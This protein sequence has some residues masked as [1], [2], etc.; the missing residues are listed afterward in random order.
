MKRMMYFSAIVMLAA[1][2]VVSLAQQKVVWIGPIYKE[3]AES[4][5][6][7]FKDY[8]LRTYG[9]PIEV[10][11]I[12]PGGWPVCV[13]KVRE[14]GGKPD[15]DVFLGAGAPAHRL[16]QNLGLTVPYK[17]AHWDAIPAEWHGMLVKDPDGYWSA[18]AP[19]LVS[20]MYNEAVLRMLNLPV[21]Q[22]WEE[23]L[24][25]RYRG[26][27]AMCL[28]YASGTMHEV[29]E[30]ILQ[31]YGEKE[32]WAYLRY[33]GAQVGRWTTGSVDTMH[34]VTRGEYPIG[35]AQPQMNAMVARRD[36]YPVG[37]LVP[38]VT[39]L[40]PESAALL[41]NAPNER[42]AK[43]F[44]DWLYSE[45]GQKYVLMGGYFPARSDISLSAWAAEGVAMAAHAISAL[46][47]KDNF[48]QLELE[49]LNYDLALAESRWDFVNK[50]FEE[51]IYRKWDELKSTLTFIEQVEAEIK[52]V[53]AT[54]RDVSNAVALVAQARALFGEGKLAEAR[55]A[56]EQARTALK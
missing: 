42:N 21:P 10:T 45:E 12:R 31:Y 4:L 53:A 34:M 17:H 44:L 26:L 2:G 27:I 51:E 47:G 15:A 5:M 7:G 30:I 48:W 8:Y 19:W 1:V 35:I 20:N 32:G 29:C 23:L 37:N 25:P 9:E 56:A 6:R 46:G 54:G 11:F 24:D 22:T 28:P 18:F 40:V 50:Y 43:I 36:G 41:T 16:L 49:L 14:W 33:L 38:N 52:R 13:D 39:I 3:L 55:T